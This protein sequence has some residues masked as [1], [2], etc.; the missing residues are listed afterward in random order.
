MT[1]IN[2]WCQRWCFALC[3]KKHCNIDI[4]DKTAVAVFKPVYYRRYVD[5]IF[6]LFRSPDHLEKFTNY[7][8]SKHKNIKFTYE[9]ESNNSLPFLDILI[10]RSENGFKTSVYHKPTFSGVYSNFNSFIYDEY[11]IGSVFTM[12]F[13]TFSIVSDFSRFHTEIIHLKEI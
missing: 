2:Q 5:D 7:L 8:N 13:R 10:S 9:K 4:E 11:K 6:A 12:L 3:N 1:L